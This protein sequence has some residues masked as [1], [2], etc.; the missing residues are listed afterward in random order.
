[1]SNSKV[2]FEH[3]K[4]WLEEPVIFFKLAINLFDLMLIDLLNGRHKHFSNNFRDFA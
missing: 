2:V 1:M 3:L 4:S